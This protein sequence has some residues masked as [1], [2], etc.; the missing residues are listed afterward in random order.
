M[1]INDQ[2]QS[3]TI[4]KRTAAELSPGD[5]FIIYIREQYIISLAFTA[6]SRIYNRE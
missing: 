4:T 3:Q 1:I 5:P 6:E 2:T